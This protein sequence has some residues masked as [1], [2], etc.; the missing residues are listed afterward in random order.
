MESSYHDV[1]GQ[2]MNI[3]MFIQK[4]DIFLYNIAVIQEKSYLYHALIFLKSFHH[5]YG[6]EINIQEWFRLILV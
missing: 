1:Y 6:Y 4:I 5:E 2:F 3:A